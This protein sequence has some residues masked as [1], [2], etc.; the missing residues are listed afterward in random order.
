MIR[1]P[2]TQDNA[3]MNVLLKDGT[4][5]IDMD[6]PDKPFGENMEVVSFWKDAKTVVVI[7]MEAVAEAELVFKDPEEVE[8]DE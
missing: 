7:P 2:Q 1:R 6:I 3:S 4:K 8:D 5:Y